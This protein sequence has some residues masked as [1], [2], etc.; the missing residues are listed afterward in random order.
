MKI[1]AIFDDAGEI[2]AAVPKDPPHPSDRY[3]PPPIP[4]AQAGQKAAEL[5]VPKEFAHLSF[6]EVC[7][8][9]R[10]DTKSHHPALV[11]SE[12]GGRDS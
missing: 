12:G 8:K 2:L 3:I 5:E 1:Y 6:H 11:L 9:M 4:V 10:V 7:T